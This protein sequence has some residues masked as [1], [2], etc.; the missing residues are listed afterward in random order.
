MHDLAL[1]DVPVPFYRS[2]TH[3]CQVEGD[4]SLTSN[5]S[6]K[7]YPCSVFVTSWPWVLYIYYTFIYICAH[8]CST[9]V[10]SLQALFPLTSHF[11]MRRAFFF[12]TSFGIFNIIL[13]HIDNFNT[14]CWWKYL[15]Y[16]MFQTAANNINIIDLNQ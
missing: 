3:S 7:L 15:Y 6:M 9:R 13:M 5:G 11:K 8:L 16:M 4:N 12:T 1:S 2:A 10:F 14:L